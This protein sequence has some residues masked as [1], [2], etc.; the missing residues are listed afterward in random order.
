MFKGVSILQIYEVLIHLESPFITPWQAD[1][2]FGHLAWAYKEL[3][4]EGPFEDWL[5]LF[6]KGR[7]PFILSDAWIKGLYPKPMIPP[8]ERTVRTYEEQLQ[9]ARKGKIFKKIGYFTE[10]MFLKVINGDYE[11]VFHEENENLLL[12][13]YRR[14][15]SLHNT[16]DREM[17]RSMQENGIYE[18]ESMYPQESQYFSIFVRVE[19]ENTIKELLH[20]FEIV[21][22]EG[23]GKKKSSGFGHFSI[24]G[25]KQRS[26]LDMA[27]S[28]GDAVLWL[29]HGVPKK[30]DPINGWYKIDTKYGKLGNQYA[31]RNNPFKKPFTR[32]QPGAVFRVEKPL[33]YYG[34]M[35]ENIHPHFPEI[36]Q[37][38]YAFAIPIKLPKYIKEERSL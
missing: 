10:H 20:L 14:N 37:Y 2:I 4:G 30:L 29:S 28:N 1:T 11:T 15:V 5:H 38:G 7:P 18:I 26:D 12:V 13:G 3:N 16:I 17:G 23:F 6:K 21:S 34:R 24:L 33:P 32:I 36:I 31:A 8:P 22:I 19:N 27:Q 25:I 35:V 9:Q